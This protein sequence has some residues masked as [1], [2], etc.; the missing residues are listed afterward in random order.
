MWVQ[1]F[2]LL[3]IAGAVGGTSAVALIAALKGKTER[4]R[5]ATV[6]ESDLEAGPTKMV[7]IEG[8]NAL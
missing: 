5:D 6:A 2:L 3:L 1:A 8:D 7:L 4:R